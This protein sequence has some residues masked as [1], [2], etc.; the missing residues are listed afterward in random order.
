M[1][2]KQCLKHQK[3][4]KIQSSVLYK[5][6]IVRK[7]S[8][9]NQITLKLTPILRIFIMS[10][11]AL[12][13]LHLL[14]FFRTH[15]KSLNISYAQEALIGTIL[16]RNGV[17]E[18]YIVTQQMLAE[19]MCVDVSYVRRLSKELI[20]KNIINVKRRGNCN[21]YS[22]SEQYRNYIA[23][24]TLATATIE[25]VTTAS[26]LSR[27]AS[28]EAHIAAT[29]EAVKDNDTIYTKINNNINI[30]HPPTK[31]RYLSKSRECQELLNSDDDETLITNLCEWRDEKS[32]LAFERD[33]DV[34][35]LFETS[36]YSKNHQKAAQ[37]RSGLGG[38]IVYAI[39][40][41]KN[42]TNVLPQFTKYST[43]FKT[44]CAE[45]PSQ[46]TDAQIK[47]CWQVWLTQNYDEISTQIIA[48]VR[49]RKEHDQF[50]ITMLSENKKWRIKPARSFLIEKFWTI[51]FT[52]I[53]DIKEGVQ[54][55]TN[56]RSRKPES[57]P[58]TSDRVFRELKETYLLAKAR[59]DAELYA[60]GSNRASPDDE[61]DY[62]YPDAWGDLENETCD[63]ISEVDSSAVYDHGRELCFF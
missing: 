44:F 52:H 21:L 43:Q 19:D 51:P 36:G 42:K 33:L 35:L 40:S 13:A 16:S 55:E 23:K 14:I 39:G 59:E 63:E 49:M 62:E 38:P 58:E 1:V 29:I 10:K 5:T 47:Q 17:N 32:A 31:T 45:W 34:E 24:N 50:W 60:S 11:P 6:E 3:R 56:Y 46:L 25:A 53:N 15:R 26:S 48:N 61:E 57:Y 18:D 4:Q 9:Y 41:S 7:I 20:D 12:N 22:I 30:N 27:T 2:V 54:H 28:N 8:K 37:S